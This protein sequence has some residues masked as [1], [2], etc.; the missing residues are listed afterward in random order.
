L[1]EFFFDE[2]FL[3][4]M[5]L[6]ANRFACI[7]KRRRKKEKN[8]T[9][10]NEQDFYTSSAPGGLTITEQILTSSKHPVTALSY[11]IIRRSFKKVS[12]LS[13]I[14]SP[15]FLQPDNGSR[16]LGFLA[17]GHSRFF[18]SSSFHP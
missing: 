11:Y 18:L 15:T 1:D 2:V 9:Q 16:T 7:R 4:G 17:I 12:I 14:F 10:I 5:A 8:P 6:Q 3:Y 13:I